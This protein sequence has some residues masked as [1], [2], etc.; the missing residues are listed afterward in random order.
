MKRPE[1]LLHH[2]DH[3]HGSESGLL[4]RHDLIETARRC[5]RAGEIDRR[6]FRGIFRRVEIGRLQPTGECQHQENDQ[7][8]PQR[9]TRRVS[10]I[11]AVR[12]RRYGSERHQEKNHDQ[13]GD[14]FVLLAMS[15]WLAGSVTVIR[16]ILSKAQASRQGAHSDT[17]RVAACHTQVTDHP[18]QGSQALPFG[19]GGHKDQSTQRPVASAALEQ[20]DHSGFARRVGEVEG[21]ST[22]GRIE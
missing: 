12:P 2:V 18:L 6:R 4:C 16:L 20:R 9:A 7:D 17:C 14:H 8:Q 13:N 15:A 21:F 22:R 5:R 3:C 1:T 10:P 19:R 11:A